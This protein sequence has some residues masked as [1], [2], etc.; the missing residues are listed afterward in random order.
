MCSTGEIPTTEYKYTY[1]GTTSVDDYDFLQLQVY[2]DSSGHPAMYAWTKR[3]LWGVDYVNYGPVQ[4]CPGPNSY[5]I[6]GF[7]VNWDGSNPPSKLDVTYN[8]QTVALSSNS[9]CE[10]CSGLPYNCAPN[11]CTKLTFWDLYKD[12]IILLTLFFASLIGFGILF[13]FLAR[14]Y[15]PYYLMVAFGVIL[16]FGL[17]FFITSEF[18]DTEKVVLISLVLGIIIGI[19]ILLILFKGPFIGYLVVLLIAALV[20]GFIY[21]LVE[22][23]EAIRHPTRTLWD[24]IK[25]LFTV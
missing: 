12:T 10:Q 23:Y 2:N 22:I 24:M 20:F 21:I 14:K 6:P 3:N 25:D 16:L 18:G 11:A 13:L 19:G 17:F 7:T 9:Q 5:P 8:Q 1:H 15:F 4:I